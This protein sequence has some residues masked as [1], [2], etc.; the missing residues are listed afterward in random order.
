MMSQPY[1]PF[2]NIL[3]T[4]ASSPTS[5]LSSFKN[6][7]CNATSRSSTATQCPSSTDFTLLQSSNVRLTPLNDVVYST[8]AS[9]PPGGHFSGNSLSGSNR[10]GFCPS[11]SR[12]SLSLIRNMFSFTD[13]NRSELVVFGSGLTGPVLND[14]AF[15]NPESFDSAVGLPD[16]NLASSSATV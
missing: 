2:T 15:L 16:D 12:S 4:A 9:A 13:L 14:S 8:T 1:L 5:S 7:P 11:F 3:G 10:T 6:S